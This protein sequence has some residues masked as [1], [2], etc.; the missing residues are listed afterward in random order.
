MKDKRLG[1]VLLVFSIQSLNMIRS[2][3]GTIVLQAVE[4]IPIE[5]RL[6]SSVTEIQSSLFNENK[7]VFA[8]GLKPTVDLGSWLLCFCFFPDFGE[9]LNHL[10]HRT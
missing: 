8:L 1:Q 10:G 9:E 7:F 6:G 4:P 3:V 5:L 2:L